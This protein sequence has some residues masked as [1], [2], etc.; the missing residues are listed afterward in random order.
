MAVWES[1]RSGA[2]RMTRPARL[3]LAALVIAVIGALL[4]LPTAE[5]GCTPTTDICQAYKP[6]GTLGLGLIALGAILLIAAFILASNS[7]KASN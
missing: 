3:V 7:G 2:S 4:L 1:L 6:Y 5:Q